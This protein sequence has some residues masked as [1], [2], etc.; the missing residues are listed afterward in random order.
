[1]TVTEQ[2]SVPRAIVFGTEQMKQINACLDEL[3]K[4]TG[5][6]DTILTDVTG[7]SIVC[8]GAINVRDAAA[9]AA[10]IAGSHAASAEFGNV[11]GKP[12]PAVNLFHEAKTYSIYSTNVADAL[13]LSVA[14]GKNVKFGMV[15]L[16]VERTCQR[17]TDII[18][19]L[20]SAPVDER[21]NLRIVDGDLDNFFDREFAEITKPT[22]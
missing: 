15:R 9:L 3:E 21:I 17:L 14:F 16:F 2:F 4:N 18:N 22:K 10:L 8:R 5:V 20:R 7:Q 12:T 13:I 19:E 11:L 1:M 6:S